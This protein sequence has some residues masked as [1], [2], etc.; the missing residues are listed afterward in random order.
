MGKGK[1]KATAKALTKGKLV[2]NAI[3][4]AKASTR[5]PKSGSSKDKPKAKSLPK[6]KK[7]FEETFEETELEEAG[8]AQ[9]Q[10]EGPNGN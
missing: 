5:K 1:P 9:P 3:A 6:A 8:G 10:R 7:H 4:K 2:K